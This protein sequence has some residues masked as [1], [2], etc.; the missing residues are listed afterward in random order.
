MT[1]FSNTDTKTLEEEGCEKDYFLSLI[2]N[3]SKDYTAKFTRKF[4][5]NVKENYSLCYKDFSGKKISK[6]E[7][8]EHNVCILEIYNVSIKKDS[9]N[10]IEDFKQRYEY[11]SS[12]RKEVGLF[13]YSEKKPNSFDNTVN[14][15]ELPF[16]TEEI[17]FSPTPAGIM[18]G[19]NSYILGETSFPFSYE[20]IL[21]GL[22]EELTEKKYSAEK[23]ISEALEDI[24]LFN[25]SD[26]TIE[27]TVETLKELI[28]ELKKYN[29]FKVTELIIKEVRNIITDYTYE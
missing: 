14:S 8:V 18:V 25:F 12:K 11:L 7:T 29:N 21:K 17:E 1:F 5:G 10:V 16:Y 22:E 6:T 3:N 27:D 13:S 9:I 24:I 20:K 23:L 15:P 26:N 4:T 19:L 28:K 2:V